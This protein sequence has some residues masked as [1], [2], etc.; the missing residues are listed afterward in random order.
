MRRLLL[1]LRQHRLLLSDRRPVL[2]EIE[3]QLL[4]P[5]PL[6]YCQSGVPQCR[7]GPHI[8]PR[9]Q[10]RVK[11]FSVP[12]LAAKHERRLARLVST[13]RSIG[14]TNLHSIW[15][16]SSISDSATFVWFRSSATISGVSPSPSVGSVSDPRLISSSRQSFALF[17]AQRCNIATEPCVAAMITILAGLKLELRI[18]TMVQHKGQ[19]GLIVLLDRS[20]YFGT[21]TPGC[22]ML[23]L[24]RS[25]QSFP[26]YLALC[27]SPVTGYAVRCHLARA[28]LLSA[29]SATY[30]HLSFRRRGLVILILILFL[31]LSLRNVVVVALG[32]ETVLSRGC[33][34]PF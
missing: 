34:R 28:D 25:Q 8:C 26:A 18:D 19:V 9:L 13:R 5:A 12:C 1:Q 14:K 27:G 17:F 7:R 21:V 10:Q 15:A 33:L 24:L 3:G 2:N 20:Q 32:A 16:P 22:K 31:I 11:H 30:L 23:S 4:E 6:R 29:I